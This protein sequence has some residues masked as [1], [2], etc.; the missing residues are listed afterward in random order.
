MLSRSIPVFTN[1][2][3]S[4]FFY[5]WVIFH[6]VY[7]SHLLI[8]SSISGHLGCFH[9][10]AIVNNAAIN[11]GMH[12]SFWISV[13]IFLDKYIE[14]ELLDQMIVLFLIFWGT[15]TLVSIVAAPIYIPTSIAQVFP[16]LHILTNTCYFLSFW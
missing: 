12:I 13:F 11:M 4:L 6:C 9:I 10:L 5:V 7:I 2:K 16:F 14:V 1:G 3:I 15:S 8:H